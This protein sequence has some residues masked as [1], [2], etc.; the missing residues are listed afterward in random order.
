MET[1]RLVAE[2]KKFVAEGKLE[3]A[4]DCF[5]RTLQIDLLNVELSQEPL[6][7]KEETD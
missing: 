6:T 4:L 1:K 7:R 5:V 2:G 3:K